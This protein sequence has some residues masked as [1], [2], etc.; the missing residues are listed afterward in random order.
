MSLT[1]ADVWEKVRSVPH[2]Y[3]RIELRPGIVTPG[4]ND[5]PRFLQQLDLPADCTGLRVL[6]LGTRDGFFAFEM[7]RRGADVLAIDYLPSSTTGFDVASAVLG[8]RVTYV[9]DNIYRV[10]PEKYGMFDVVLFLGLLYHLP[11]PL[12]ALGI[13]HSVCKDLLI[14]ETQLLDNHL[15]LPDGRA[16]PLGAISSELQAIPLAQFFPA[17]TLSNDYSNYWAPNAKCME[18]MLVESSFTVLHSEVYGTRGVFKC[19]VGHD[20]LL[21]FNMRIARGIAEPG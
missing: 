5:T 20:A 6:D 14:L 18:M 12:C 15:L 9:Q 13:V 2:W 4:I 19:Q 16:V 10:T 1:D 11:D 8:S 7:E 17:N 3:H 21:D